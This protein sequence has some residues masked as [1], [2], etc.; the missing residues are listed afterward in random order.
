MF[1]LLC[2]LLAMWVL[3]TQCA[4]VRKTSLGRWWFILLSGSAFVFYFSD[5]L[6][7][8]CLSWSMMGFSSQAIVGRRPTFPTRKSIASMVVHSTLSTFLCFSALFSTCAD[9]DQE[10]KLA[11]LFPRKTMSMIQS[12]I[13]F[14]SLSVKSLLFPFSTWLI[15]A[16]KGVALMSS[17][18]HSLTIVASGLFLTTFLLVEGW[19]WLGLVEWTSILFL[20]SS[21]WHLFYLLRENH[22]K[23]L[24]AWSTA[25]SVNLAHVL[26]P[27]DLRFSLLYGIFHGLSKSFLFA[28]SQGKKDLS[29]SLLAGLLGGFPLSFVWKVKTSFCHD[30]L[31][32]ST[33]LLWGLLAYLCVFLKLSFKT[34]L[35]VNKAS[36]WVRFGQSWFTSAILLSLVFL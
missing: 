25:F 5:H 11:L 24:L 8:M 14:L 18:V 35:S 12:F 26:L 31:V 22:G 33:F 1:S 19:F 9:L 16:M 17:L 32:A 3:S 21:L 23:R 34:L 36:L 28:C 4:L 2:L 10:W 30:S 20:P 27:W 29:W 7:W 15:S 13:C 6:V